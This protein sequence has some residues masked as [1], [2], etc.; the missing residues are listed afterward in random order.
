[1]SEI[2]R[3]FLERWHGIIAERNAAALPEIIAE[4]A[5]FRSPFFFAPQEGREYMVNVLSAVIQ[6]LEDFTYHREL[7]DGSTLAL[8]FSARVGEL[9]VKGIDLIE[10]DANGRVAELEVFIR[11]MNGLQAVGKEMMQRLTGAD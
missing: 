11:P 1:M 9:S 4:D 3:D 2:A 5:S 8:E 10:L 6:V 7:V